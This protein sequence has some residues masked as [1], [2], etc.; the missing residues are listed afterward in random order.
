M[1]RNAN[2]R[3]YYYGPAEISSDAG[4]VYKMAVAI[5]FIV[6]PESDAPLHQLH[7]TAYPRH[8]G[9]YQVP[10]IY[11]HGYYYAPLFSFFLG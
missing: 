7:N 1:D 9:R 6:R 4:H 2:I 8:P 5:L 3:N 11:F 10:A